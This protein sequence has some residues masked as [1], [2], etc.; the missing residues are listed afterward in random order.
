MAKK[1]RTPT[2]DAAP[3]F[4][5][6]PFSAL[7]AAKLSIPAAPTPAPKP[8]PPTPEPAARLSPADRALLRVFSDAAISVG[9][10]NDAARADLPTGPLRGR[11]R[12]QIQRKGKGG[13]TVTRVLGLD[14]LSIV[15]QMELAR[16]LR[17]ALGTGAHFD[18]GTLELHGDLRDRAADWFRSHHY[19]VL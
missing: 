12:L 5:V 9:S 18:E 6:N 2:A 16:E 4:K 15:D 19:A 11:V 3:E 13:K 1:K 14:A 7:S 8:A 10:D 17:Q